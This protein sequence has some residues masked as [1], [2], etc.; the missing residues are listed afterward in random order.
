MPDGVA[1]FI[2]YRFNNHL[3]VWLIVA[4]FIELK[5][6]DIVNT[7]LSNRNIVRNNEEEKY[8]GNR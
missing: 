8:Q 1:I 4:K 3:K 5:L 7:R 2:K 6:F